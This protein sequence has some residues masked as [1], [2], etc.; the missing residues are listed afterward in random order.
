[1]VIFPY[2]LSL[3]FCA[4]VVLVGAFLLLL[5]WRSRAAVAAAPADLPV[6]PSRYGPEQTNRWLKLI[7][8]AFIL[9]CV[10]A[11]AFHAYWVFWAP[12][13]GP[14]WEPRISVPAPAASPLR[15][16]RRLGSSK[17]GVRKWIYAPP[18]PS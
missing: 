9:L 14:R 1:M 11:L 18:A 5:A 17:C 2:T 6:D 7:R 4:G 10:A 3:V 16:R 8:T 13:C 15:E 12:G